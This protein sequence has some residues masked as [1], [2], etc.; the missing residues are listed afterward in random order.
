MGLTYSVRTW[1]MD[2]QAFTPQVGLSQPWHGLSMW[3]LKQ[4]LK[5]LKAMGYECHRYRDENGGH[6]CNDT[7]V[8]VEREDLQLKRWMGQ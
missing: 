4:A 6:E 8:L 5:E 7:S 1:D 2:E 3:Q